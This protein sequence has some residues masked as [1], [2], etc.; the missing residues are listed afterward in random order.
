MKMLHFKKSTG[1]L[2]RKLEEY[3]E[4]CAKYYRLHSSRNKNF[5]KV[6]AIEKVLKE[7]YLSDNLDFEFSFGRMIEE[8]CKVVWEGGISEKRA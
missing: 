3:D 5:Y 8:N 6:K 2:P 1:L 4:L 7:K